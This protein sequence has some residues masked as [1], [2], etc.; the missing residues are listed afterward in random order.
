M[1]KSWSSG[2]LTR[3]RESALLAISTLFKSFSCLAAAALFR[4]D[5]R[6]SKKRVRLC[7]ANTKPRWSPTTGKSPHLQK[8]TFVLPLSFPINVFV[9]ART[10]TTAAKKWTIQC[11]IQWTIA[12]WAEQ[13]G[14][15]KIELIWLFQFRQES[16]LFSF[17]LVSLWLSS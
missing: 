5:Y 6:Q 13:Q 7:N 8:F 16:G 12:Q 10:P 1:A 14:A 15:W 3:S 4:V 11:T 17:L 9:D 2:T